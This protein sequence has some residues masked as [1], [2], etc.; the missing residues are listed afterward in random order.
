MMEKQRRARCDCTLPEGLKASRGLTLLNL[1]K[2]IEEKRSLGSL[3]LQE[4]FLDACCRS[5]VSTLSCDLTANPPRMFF[6]WG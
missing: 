5:W 4:L 6:K 3:E 1:R 2:A